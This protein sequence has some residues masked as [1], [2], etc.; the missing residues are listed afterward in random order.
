MNN[1]QLCIPA[2]NLTMHSYCAFSQIIILI[3]LS[4][5]YN[6]VTGDITLKKII[7]NNISPL[8]PGEMGEQ[9]RI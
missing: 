6:D 3:G 7:S 1:V 2:K 9:D 5:S 8:Y 4:K